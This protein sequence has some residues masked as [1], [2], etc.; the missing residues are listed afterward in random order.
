VDIKII[1]GDIIM[2]DTIIMKVEI[3]GMENIMEM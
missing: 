1:M 2:T 3:M